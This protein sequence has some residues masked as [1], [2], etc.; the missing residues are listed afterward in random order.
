MDLLKFDLHEAVLIGRNGVDVVIVGNQ[1]FM[2]FE[3]QHQFPVVVTDQVV[4]LH[5]QQLQKHP[6]AGLFRKVLGKSTLLDAFCQGLAFVFVVS[7]PSL[8]LAR[9]FV[10]SKPQVPVISSLRTLEQK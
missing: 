3:F 8:R 9:L 5:H 2:V 6:E 1:Q 7:L 4:V 10:Q